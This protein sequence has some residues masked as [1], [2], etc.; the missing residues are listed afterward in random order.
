MESGSTRV[1]NLRLEIGVPSTQRSDR[2]E[3]IDPFNGASNGCDNFIVI[4]VSA[5]SPGNCHAKERD[6]KG[7]GAHLMK[8][9]AEVINSPGVVIVV[10]SASRSW[11][12][13]I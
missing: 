6:R 10:F 4:H 12:L 8:A 13:S 5:M 1:I 2:H 11:S 3:L 7:G 9:R